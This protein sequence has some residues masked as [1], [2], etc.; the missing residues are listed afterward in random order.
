MFVCEYIKNQDGNDSDVKSV[1]ITYLFRI[2]LGRLLQD[3]GLMYKKYDR[4]EFIE[5]RLIDQQILFYLQ[6]NW[7][8]FFC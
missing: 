6:T 5:S 3:P 2:S 4:K 1:Q 7:I 8:K